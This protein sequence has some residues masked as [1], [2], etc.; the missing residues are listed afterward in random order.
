MNILLIN[1]PSIAAYY[2]LGIK[3]P[4]LGLAYLAAVLREHGHEVTIIDLAGEDVDYHAY[5]Y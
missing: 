3:L 4:P 1:P 2:R 5:P